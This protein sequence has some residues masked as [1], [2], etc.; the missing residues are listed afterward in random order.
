MPVSTGLFVSGQ[1]LGDTL[2]FD[3]TDWVRNNLIYNNGTSIGIA[4]QT[5][6]YLL[7]V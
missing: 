1:T 3:G 4:D 6:S 7:D 2:R 5:P